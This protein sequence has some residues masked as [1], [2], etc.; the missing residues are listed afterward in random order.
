MVNLVED[1]LKCGRGVAGSQRG[2]GGLGHSERLSGAFSYPFGSHE[3]GTSTAKSYL[4][5]GK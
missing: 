4:D 1:G 2:I 5:V 3:R